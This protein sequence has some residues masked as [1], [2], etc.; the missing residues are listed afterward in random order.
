MSRHHKIDYIE[1][2][3]PDLAAAKAFYGAAF[4]WTFT[5]YGDE[6]VGIQGEPGG[7]EVGGFNPRA[8]P[9]TTGSLVI[10]YSDDLEATVAAVGAAGGTVVAGPYDFPGGRRF[11]F[12]DP[13]GNRLAAWSEQTGAA[14][15]GLPG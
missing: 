12:T 5:D 15:Y 10:L 8:E 3:T 2:A 4:G 14:G 11:E 9:G 1:F 13:A 6:Y 7:P